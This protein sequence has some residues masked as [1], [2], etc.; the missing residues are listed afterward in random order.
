[1]PLGGG[2]ISRLRLTWDLDML[3]PSQYAALLRQELC[4]R[5]AAYAALHKLPHEPAMGNRL[6]LFFS[7]QRAVANTVISSPPATGQ[8]SAERNGAED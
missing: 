4:A 1:M 6:L 7:R 3:C 2:L 5:N 8:F